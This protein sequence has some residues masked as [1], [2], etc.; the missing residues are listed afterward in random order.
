M[1]LHF[2]Y[3][4]APDFRIKFCSYFKVKTSKLSKNYLISAYPWIFSIYIILAAGF[5]YCICFFY[6]DQLRSPKIQK[7]AGWFLQLI[8][9]AAILISSWQM[10]V[11]ITIVTVLLV[12]EFML[13]RNGAWSHTELNSDRAKI[14]IVCALL[15][16]TII[17]IFPRIWLV[18]K[19]LKLLSCTIKLKI[20]ARK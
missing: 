5:S 10:S 19:N 14:F 8:G 3:G 1:A 16:K 12:R 6:E 20:K 4:A 15:E 9:I 11:N 2:C 17:M 18:W 7:I 13:F